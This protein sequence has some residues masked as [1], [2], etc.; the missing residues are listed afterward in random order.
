[1]LDVYESE[2]KS[3]IEWYV[4]AKDLAIEVDDFSDKTYIQPLHELRYSYDH[5]MRA[6][7]YER[8]N[9]GDSELVKRAIMSAKGHLLRAYSDCIEW[10]LVTVKAEYDRV[11]Q[12]TNQVYSAE[13]INSVFPEYYQYIR[14]ELNQIT[15]AVTEYKK[16]KK[17]EQDSKVIDN[18]GFYDAKFISTLC[19][20]AGGFFDNKYAKKLKEYLISIQNAEVDLIKV[21]KTKKKK[22]ALQNI[23]IPIATATAAALI[24]WGITFAI[25]GC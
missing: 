6:V 18:D 3:L 15:V 21:K 11:L 24:A 9:A 7:I 17:I 20:D 22:F 14:T 23:L 5:F 8:N 2:M 16:H 13:E 4:R 10:L 25:T 1:M 19:D 12:P